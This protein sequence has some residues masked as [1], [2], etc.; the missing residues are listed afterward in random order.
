MSILC[1]TAQAQFYSLS[2]NLV[3]LGTGTINAELSF[4]LNRQWTMHIPVQD[5]PLI[6]KD[7]R[8]L[9]NVTIQPE[10]RYWFLE[11][12]YRNFFGIYAIASRFH[13]GKI[14]D[15]YRY[16]GQAFGTG[17]SYGQTYPLSKRLNLEWELG[18]GL[19][20]ADYTKYKCKKCGEI[21][22]RESGF[23]F[24]PTRAALNISY[25]F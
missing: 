9:R 15:D 4:A 24:I 20:W 5:N 7:N 14:W 10:V 1:Y 13:I 25:L 17:L 16:D 8:Q 2:T 6:L 19:V 3:G 11:S 22:G 21:I 23:H 12:Y 18:A